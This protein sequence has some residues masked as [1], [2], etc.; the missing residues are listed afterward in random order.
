MT[1][2]ILMVIDVKESNG[3]YYK[4]CGN[5]LNKEDIAN[6]QVLMVL[7]YHNSVKMDI[8]ITIMKKTS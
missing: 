5:N 1:C 8:D 2:I 3:T 6:V 4:C 7:H